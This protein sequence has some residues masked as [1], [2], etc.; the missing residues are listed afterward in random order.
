[1]PHNSNPLVVSQIELNLHHIIRL[2]IYATFFQLMCLV[3]YV[4]V[5]WPP[6]V[7]HFSQF[8]YT[9]SFNIEVA[10]P[11]CTISFTFFDKLK[12]VVLVPIFIGIFMSLVSKYFA[13]QKHVN[14][15]NNDVNKQRYYRKK[16]KT[17]RQILVIFVTSIYTPVCYYS[18]RMFESCVETASGEVVMAG[19]T[20]LSCQSASYSFHSMFA[21]VALVIFGVGIPFGIVALI[22]YLKRKHLLNSGAS[23]Q[24]YGALYEWYSDDYAWFEAVSLARKG[25][26]LL[27]VTLLSGEKRASEA[28]AAGKV[29]FVGGVEILNCSLPPAVT[30]TIVLISNPTT[31]RAHRIIALISDSIQ[32]A[33]GMMVITLAYA[34]VIIVFSPFIRFPLRLQVVDKEVD[35][36][37]FLEAT[38]AVATGFDLLLGTL[39]AID[40]TREAASAIGVTFIL[41]NS[42]IIVLAV[43]SF[44][45]G[46]RRKKNKD[47]DKDKKVKKKK[48]RGKRDSLG[49]EGTTMTGIEAL[50]EANARPMQWNDVFDE[51]DDEVVTGGS[52]TI[53]NRRKLMMMQKKKGGGSSRRMIG[54]ANLSL[55]NFGVA[56]IREEYAEVLDTADEDCK[57]LS[58]RWTSEYSMM[59]EAKAGCNYAEAGAIKLQLE[60]TRAKLLDELKNL[61]SSLDV[62]LTEEERRGERGGECD[63][64]SAKDNLRSAESLEKHVA[65][66]WRDSQQPR[67]TGKLNDLKKSHDEFLDAFH[68]ELRGI[69]KKEAF[70]SESGKL[71]TNSEGET[72][73]L[74]RKKEREMRGRKRLSLAFSTSLRGAA[75][76]SLRE[77]DR[78]VNATEELLADALKTNDFE[79]AFLVEVNL[80]RVIEQYERD[81]EVSGGRIVWGLRWEG[82]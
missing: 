48:G 52:N 12:M 24:R 29:A 79:V 74:R 72:N 39:S 59:L 20:R 2:K 40:K 8:F 27:P 73:A 34:L 53:E 66:F 9:L 55:A 21:W 16:W 18:L 43:L 50:A 10:H 51:R 42:S 58:E 13:Y 81:G 49:G 60:K 26:M 67:L 62:K 57:E 70:Q 11:E 30:A 61:A 78:I 31:F 47:K 45:S 17:L 33:G 77:K 68:E 56:D 65:K 3:M 38:T 80:K 15:R 44:E 36:Y 22:I 64:A 4:E 1:M 5:P 37:N 32:Q 69:L 46:L 23:L 71:E 82:A 54:A 75:E 35:F 19:D 76:K 28:R 7:K 41:V 14:E 6:M 63:I 25:L